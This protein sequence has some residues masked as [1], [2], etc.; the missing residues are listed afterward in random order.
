MIACLL[1]SWP[2]LAQT[3]RNAR[4]DQFWLLQVE[5]SKASHSFRLTQD[6]VALPEMLAALIVVALSASFLT[7]GIYKMESGLVSR[8]A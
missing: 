7:I 4:I 8:T 3:R 2:L 5:T 6:L 1:V